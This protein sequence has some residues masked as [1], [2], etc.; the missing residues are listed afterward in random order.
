MFTITITE[1]QMSPGEEES[2]GGHFER[3]RQTVDELDLAA[4]VALVNRP[5]RKKR[6]DAG[7]ART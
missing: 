1:K 7:K 4:I 2:G 6:A 3:Y 5:T